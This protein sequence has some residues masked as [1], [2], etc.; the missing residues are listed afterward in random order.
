[1]VTYEVAWRRVGAL[2]WRRL[3]NVKGDG[4]V[5][6]NQHFAE[7]RT[8]GAIFEMRYFIQ[9]D[10]T[11]TEISTRGVEFRFSKERFLRITELMSQAAGQQI[12]TDPR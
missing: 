4:F 2:R 7:D 1:M 8:L 12:V 3:S 6:D 11:R 5:A 10:E 9:V